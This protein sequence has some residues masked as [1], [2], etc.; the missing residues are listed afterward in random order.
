MSKI[1]RKLKTLKLKIR[2]ASLKARI[3]D[4]SE[5]INDLDA[6]TGLLQYAQYLS[7]LTSFQ[8]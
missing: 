4:L 8:N 3:T 5:Q 2:T 7:C 1:T 6:N